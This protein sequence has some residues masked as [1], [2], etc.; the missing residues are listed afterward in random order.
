MQVKDIPIIPK[1]EQ[2]NY[3]KEM[4]KL[5]GD[6]YLEMTVLPLLH[7]A[8]N[9]CDMIRPPDPITFIANFMLINKDWAK[10][11]E[12]IISEIP[13]NAG[14]KEEVNLMVSDDIVDE[15]FEEEIVKEK[16]KEEEKKEEENKIINEEENKKK[17]E[18]K[19]LG[20]SSK[21]TK[22]KAVKKK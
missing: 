20:D 5:P 4:E 7:N 11:L 13:E 6:I 15:K 17:D 16:E 19:K 2:L 21:K 1:D 8:I 14:K 18:G 12:N 3:E 9:M 22:A 10:N